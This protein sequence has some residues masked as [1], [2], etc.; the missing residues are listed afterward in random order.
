V[1]SRYVLPAMWLGWAACWWALSHDVKRPARRESVKS[2]LGHLLP[3]ACAVA[4][5]WLPSVPVPALEGRFLP[6]S[7]WSF[8]FGAAVTLAG[9]LFAVWARVHLGRNW[10]GIVTVKHD[11]ELVT[12]GPYRIVRHPIYTGLLGA[13]AG[14][15]VALGR[16]RGAVA[17]VIVALALVRKLKLEERWMSGAFGRA[18]D[19]YRR[20]VAAL[21]PMVF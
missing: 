3:F 18:Y 4:L 11:H 14:S 13:F 1:I 5:L 21:I 2:R 7:M 15:A 8:W 19:D 12:T 20:R 10:S 9:L 17:V 6:R 16:W